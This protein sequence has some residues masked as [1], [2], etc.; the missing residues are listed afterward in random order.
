MPTSPSLFETIADSTPSSSSSSFLVATSTLLNQPLL[1]F[2]YSRLLLLLSLLSFLS[3]SCCFN[4]SSLY[5]LTFGHHSF[6]L[7]WPV[8]QLS[9]PKTPHLRRNPGLHQ[10]P[11]RQHSIKVLELHDSKYHPGVERTFASSKKIVA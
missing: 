4:K 8:R 11:P 10:I 1:F 3:A 5:T 2:Q 9:N 6:A 7:P